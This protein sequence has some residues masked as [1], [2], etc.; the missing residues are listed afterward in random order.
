[1]LAV[2]V[3]TIIEMVEEGL[4]QPT[5][6]FFICLCLSFF[7]AAIIHPTEFFCFLPFLLYMLCIPS[8]YLLLTVYSVINLN[9]VSWGT[10]EGHT[11]SQQNQEPNKIKANK[12]EFLEYFKVKNLFKNND[13][14]KFIS[15]VCCS[16]SAP[17]Q[18]HKEVLKEIC[19][20]KSHLHEFKEI[21]KTCEKNS[22]ETL[23]PL[24]GLNS[25]PFLDIGDNERDISFESMRALNDSVLEDISLYDN[26]NETPVW[27]KDK[28]FQTF[29]EQQLN[30]EESEFWRQFIDK[31]LLPLDRDPEHEDK[32]K[33]DLK[34][35]RDK[36][37]SAFGLLNSLFILLVL[38][39]QLH[40]DIFNFQ[41]PYKQSN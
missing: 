19:E 12:N 1:M 7:V 30:S 36:I 2:I 26:Q 14:S 16:Q 13:G 21:L 39:L 40:Q 10:R 6:I 17:E 9:V 38:L 3:S 5:A 31:Y 32:V 22:N 35:L 23:N 18:E 29:T 4:M 37:A 20:L 24:F 27:A 15:C 34:E 33:Y 25:K 11:P 28:C 41:V 8:M